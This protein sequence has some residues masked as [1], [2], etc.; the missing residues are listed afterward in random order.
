[1]RSERCRWAI[2]FVDNIIILTFVRLERSSKIV[3]W[4]DN[5]RNARERW[6]RVCGVRLSSLYLQFERN[7]H[8]EYRVSIVGRCNEL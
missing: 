5:A 7:E 8:N 6:R 3:L 1:M 2:I 4:D